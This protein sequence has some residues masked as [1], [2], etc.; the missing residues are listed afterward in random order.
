[1]HAVFHHRIWIKTAN[2]LLDILSGSYSYINENYLATVVQPV[3][4][5]RPAYQGQAGHK[6]YAVL[7]NSCY[8]R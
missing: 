8:F 3:R 2:I 6:Y 7:S 5:R 4:R 1:M